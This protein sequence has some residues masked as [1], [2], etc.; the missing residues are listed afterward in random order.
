[1]SPQFREKLASLAAD[2]LTDAAGGYGT[3]DAER[4]LAGYNPLLAAWQAGMFPGGDVRPATFPAG[5]GPG[6]GLKAVFGLP[7]RLPALQLPP[8]AELAGQAAS[9]PLAARLE[10]LTGWL[11]PDGR[12]VTATDELTEADAADAARW[13]G[14]E[15][16]ELPSLW[17]CA[18]ATGWL[19]LADEPG[20]LAR[21]VPGE[22]AGCWPGADAVVTLHVWA[23]LLAGVLATT[24]DV[25]ASLDP[26]T[27][28]RLSFRG[29]G[30]AVAVA[31]FLARRDGLPAADV[32]DLIRDGALDGMAQA[33]TRKAWDAWVRDHGDPARV[34]LRALADLGA[35]TFSGEGTVLLTSL[36]LWA[37]RA[38][39][40]LSGVEVPLLPSSP[41]AMTA[42]H[43]VAL[44][45][46]V[47][48]PELTAQAAAWVTAR[49]PGQA[50]RE[51]LAFAAA[52]EPRERLLAVR[53][54]RRIGPGAERAWRDSL[55]RPELRVYARIAL[56]VL[57]GGM[58]DNTMPFVVEPDPDDLTWMATDLLALACGDD[59][60]DPDAIAAQFR[61]AVPAGEESWIFDLMSR[62]SHPDVVRVLGVLGRYHP[63]RKVARD[64]RKA[65]HARTRARR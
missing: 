44:A 39:F 21:A 11:G 19:D 7:A 40:A 37:L 6:S 27:S 34:L 25:A 24:L 61:E 62:G 2:I 10:A 29:Q 4:L 26:R 20:G 12:V 18:L 47:T 5:Y 65:A 58:P 8:E 38:Q 49:G 1:M 64:A 33:R 23:V 14:L 31:L 13:L 15:V 50:A 30:V 9:A 32:S 17:E 36:A 43:L 57:A 53:I 56:A 54:V 28:R 46:G 63:D 45:D 22:I 52:G 48:E 55:K 3:G 42:A 51:L 35:V 41:A 59:D 16:G 60:P